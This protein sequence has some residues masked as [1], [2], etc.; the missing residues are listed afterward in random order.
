MVVVA[1]SVAIALAVAVAVSIAVAVGEGTTATAIALKRSEK[2]KYSG[3][4]G[5]R[6]YNVKGHRFGNSGV[7]GSDSSSDRNGGLRSGRDTAVVAA[8]MTQAAS[9]LHI[10]QQRQGQQ[11]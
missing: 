1:V 4:I 6:S 2:Q 3:S 11:R 8:A 10:L 5:S 9:T 7:G